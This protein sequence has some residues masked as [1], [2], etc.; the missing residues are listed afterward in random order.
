MAIADYIATAGKGTGGE[1]AAGIRSGF[2]MG[3]TAKRTE[4]A[5]RGMDLR[6]QERTDRLGQ[7][8]IE[9]EQWNR[10]RSDKWLPAVAT[11]YEGLKDEDK[12][13]MLNFLRREGA[14]EGLDM[15]EFPTEAG[16]DADL[17]MSR[18]A[19]E[20]EKEKLSYQ[21]GEGGKLF[22]VRG[23]EATEVSG[24]RPE[25]PK[26]AKEEK[27]RIVSQGGIQYYA[28]DG[29]LVLPDV[30]PGAKGARDYTPQQYTEL[31]REVND[32]DNA[33]T[34]VDEI[35]TLL[36]TTLTG[37]LFP[38]A[39]G[40]VQDLLL[41]PFTGH[42]FDQ[43]RVRQL[44]KSFVA[45]VAPTLGN[46]PR[47]TLMVQQAAEIAISKPGLTSGEDL[48]REVLAALKVK[49]IKERDLVAS[50]LSKSPQSAVAGDMGGGGV[51]KSTPFQD[52]LKAKLNQ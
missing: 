45:E 14:Q 25:A 41:T 38:A 46:N 42:T 34:K 9:N 30:K 36:D 4:L 10:E 21:K 27:R 51:L 17:F 26:P 2:G 48:T 37:G 40:A 12:P 11:M 22:A 18:H 28:D 43:Q 8:S 35:I 23:D 20:P 1:L 29:S 33:V 15:A 39:K 13:A 31:R 6:E 32:M 16:P 50:E 5:E 52:K 47:L 7:Y 19:E 44:L 24:F 3:Q 49:V